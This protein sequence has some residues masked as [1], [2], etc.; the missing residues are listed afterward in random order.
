MHHFG[1]N[2][3]HDYYFGLP[4]EGERAAEINFPVFYCTP[5]R[6]PGCAAC[7]PKFFACFCAGRLRSAD[8]ASFPQ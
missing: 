1:R 5:S 2:R 6:F 7:E 4:S 8:C 3:D